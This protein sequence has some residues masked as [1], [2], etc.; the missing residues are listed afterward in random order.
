MEHGE[1]LEV[2]LVE[3][4]DMMKLEL[5]LQLDADIGQQ[6]LDKLQ[7]DTQSCIAP[8]LRTKSRQPWTA[9][10]DCMPPERQ[11]YLLMTDLMRHNSPF[12]C[13]SRGSDASATRDLTTRPWNGADL[14]E[15]PQP[16]NTY[17]SAR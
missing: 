2:F 16:G 8:K 14:T 4:G 6:A 11:N 5:L 1:K 9:L 10:I 15:L 3:T 7:P 12:I 13:R 17:L